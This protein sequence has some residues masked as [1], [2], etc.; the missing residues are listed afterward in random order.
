MTDASTPQTTLSLKEEA[1]E[2]PSQQQT[3]HQEE[4]SHN[5]A[6]VNTIIKLEADAVDDRLNEQS[7]EGHH[8]FKKRMV[9]CQIEWQ[10]GHD[11]AAER[12]DEK[13]NQQVKP[14]SSSCLAPESD[15]GIPHER[16]ENFSQPS[17]SDS[18]SKQQY[19]LKHKNVGW[20]SQP[21]RS[22][23]QLLQRQPT[24]QTAPF[25]RPNLTMA[26]NDSKQHQ[27]S[28]APHGFTA[29]PGGPLPHQRSDQYPLPPQPAPIPPPVAMM[30]PYPS[31]SYVS[32]TN[33]DVNSQRYSQQ[34]QQPTNN[35][36]GLH[37]YTETNNSFMSGLNETLSKSA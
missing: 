12:R 21:A 5:D 28:N 9:Q 14:E 34:Y 36:G 17:S 26:P 27:N 2:V 35:R 18:P 16:E 20:N 15:Q 6:L 3:P 30:D 4:S 8:H 19:Y 13:P 32:P 31:S 11:E 7:N 37:P 25:S 10:S 29:Y 23:P 33:S 1:H 24:E 22:E